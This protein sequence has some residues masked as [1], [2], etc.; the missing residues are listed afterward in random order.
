[1]L[2]SCKR[3]WRG[4]GACKSVSL[5]YGSCLMTG[6]GTSKALGQDIAASANGERT[7][8]FEWNGH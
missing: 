5:I 3:P 4:E 7:D 8:D 1:M 6:S 2:S